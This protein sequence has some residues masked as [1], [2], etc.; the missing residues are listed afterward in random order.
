MR[1]VPH[2]CIN[3]KQILLFRLEVVN[4]RELEVLTAQIK[5]EVCACLSIVSIELVA[6]VAQPSN[7]CEESEVLCNVDRNTW[8]NTNVPCVSLCL[9]SNSSVTYFFLYLVFEVLVT[10]A[11]L[12]KYAYFVPLSESVAYIWLE[13]IVVRRFISLPECSRPSFTPIESLSSNL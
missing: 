3:L 4:E 13:C 5:T 9:C 1:L 2:S 11:T 12:T 6:C 10:E 8:T 7:L